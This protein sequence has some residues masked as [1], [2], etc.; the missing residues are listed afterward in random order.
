MNRP[1]SEAFDKVTQ[2]AIALGVSNLKDVWI[3]KID[4][5]WT[6]ALNGG[7]EATEVDPGLS[8]K[9]TVDPINVAVWFNGWLCASLSPF[10]G[11]FFSGSAANEDTFI[12]ALDVALANQEAVTV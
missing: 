8:M 9:A 5:R 3:H 10:E 7:D 2:L 4:E 12:A 11:I 6:I 1:I